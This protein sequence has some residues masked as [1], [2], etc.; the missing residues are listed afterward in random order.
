MAVMYINTSL[1]LIMIAFQEKRANIE[2]EHGS[3]EE[4]NNISTVEC[5]VY[6]EECVKPGSKPDGN[7]LTLFQH[8]H[9]KCTYRYQLYYSI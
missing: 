8:C 6:T 9:Y 2:K 3:T 1:Y 7:L 4:Y 5:T